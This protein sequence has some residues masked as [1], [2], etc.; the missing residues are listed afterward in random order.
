MESGRITESPENGQRARI[1]SSKPQCPVI[2]QITPRV[3]VVMETAVRILPSVRAGIS[4]AG[5]HRRGLFRKNGAVSRNLE[6]SA[7]NPAIPQPGVF[8][9]LA[10][11]QVPKG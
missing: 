4:P 3:L 7:Y 9:G 1:G 10:L 5:G 11:A 8:C 2:M 6:T